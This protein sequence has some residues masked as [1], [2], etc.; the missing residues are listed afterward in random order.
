MSEIIYDKLVRDK[1]PEIIENSGKKHEVDYLNK[2]QHFEYLNR[3][4]IEEL[5]EYQENNSLEELADILEV[6][7]GILSVNNQ[8]FEEL[9]NIRQE[10]L[11]KRG[12]FKKGIK[13]IKVM[14]E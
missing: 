5:N 4:L 3:K 9:E 12:G 2:E 6:I 8:T 7:H 1:I 11:K 14:D 10:K 13:L